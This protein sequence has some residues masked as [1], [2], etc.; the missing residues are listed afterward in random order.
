MQAKPSVFKSTA[1]YG[2]GNL[3]LRAVNFL[4]LPLYSQVLSTEEFGNYALIL[5]F[6]SIALIIYQAGFGIGFTKFYLDET[7]S[8]KRK[9]VFSG[10]LNTVFIISVLL[11]TIGIIFKNQIS[12]LLL[13]SSA[14][15]QLFFIVFISLFFENI[16]FFLLYYFKILEKSKFVVFITA[17]SSTVN[18]LLNIILVYFFAFGIE[19]I[20][21]SLL[22]SN[23]AAVIILAPFV[24]KDYA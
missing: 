15:A 17:I 18:F 13:G 12:L 4:L 7:D 16:L 1:W 2:A 14:F 23:A 3:I 11:S 8:E 24:F 5:A 6:Y 10:I 22:V 9:T 20:L 21:I 19:G